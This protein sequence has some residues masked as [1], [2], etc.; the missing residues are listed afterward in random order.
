MLFNENVR[1]FLYICYS[2]HHNPK[3]ILASG[4]LTSPSSWALKVS[5]SQAEAVAADT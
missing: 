2:F 3:A 5:D 4:M 1:S